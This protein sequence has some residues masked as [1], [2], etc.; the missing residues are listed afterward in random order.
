MILVAGT[1]MRC[2]LSIWHFSGSGEAP[3]TVA[4]KMTKVWIL[5]SA[6]SVQLG[7]QTRTKFQCRV[8][9]TRW[10]RGGA[11]QVEWALWG[12]ILN[13]LSWG[14]RFVRAPDFVLSVMG[15]PLE[16]FEKGTIALQFTLSKIIQAVV[17]C[18]NGSRREGRL[19]PWSRREMTLSWGWQKAVKFWVYFEGRADTGFAGRLDVELRERGVKVDS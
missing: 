13:C 4:I 9:G 12:D 2:M 19:L 15:T 10:K 11:G 5:S 1:C 18:K 6:N 3:G 17:W 8:S 16:G 7:R 14:L